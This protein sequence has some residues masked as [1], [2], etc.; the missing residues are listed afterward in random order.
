MRMEIDFGSG[1]ILGFGVGTALM[2]ILDSVMQYL[3]D[4]RR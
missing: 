3:E 4:A 2:L 1:W